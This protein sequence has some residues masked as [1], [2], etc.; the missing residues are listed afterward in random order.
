MTWLIPAMNRAVSAEERVENWN[1][2]FSTLEFL[3]WVLG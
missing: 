3:S 1:Q 2:N